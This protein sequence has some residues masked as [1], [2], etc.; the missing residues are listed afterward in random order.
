LP[1]TAFSILSEKEFLKQ[2]VFA[3]ISGKCGAA[4][5]GTPAQLLAFVM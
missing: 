3:M 5:A 1:L 4:Q 2:Q